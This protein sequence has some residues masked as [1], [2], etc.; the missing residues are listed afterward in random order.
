MDMTPNQ[1]R[2]FLLGR[3]TPQRAQMREDTA[4]PSRDQ[5]VER[6][7]QIDRRLAVLD[8]ALQ[9]DD[10]AQIAART[11]VSI[12]TVKEYID[13]AYQTWQT[14]YLEKTTQFKSKLMAR[15]EQM[16]QSLSPYA[17]GFVGEDGKAQ[18]PDRNY[19]KSALDVLK[20]QYQMIRDQEE[21][22]LKLSEKT[23]AQAGLDDIVPT[24][25]TTSDLYAQALSA[26][27]DAGEAGVYANMSAE[28]LI[29]PL[30]RESLLAD[31]Q[32]SKEAMDTTVLPGMVKKIA[33]ME[34]MIVNPLETEDHE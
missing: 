33:R 8:M 22:A 30:K 16:Y 19:S 12:N 10:L 23:R 15:L 25:A 21:M 28:D 34:E 24:F 14:Q 31:I 17:L 26:L 11:G 13:E 2:D 18:P 3:T 32:L 9:T 5:R 7:R 6:L 1:T 4:Q 29:V 20:L 27:N